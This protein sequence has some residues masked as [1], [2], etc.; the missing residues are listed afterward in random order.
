[1]CP[2]CRLANRLLPGPAAAIDVMSGSMPW[3]E[4]RSPSTGT[5][6]SW[7]PEGTWFTTSR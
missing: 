6:A 5:S 2:V 1:M 3:E 4:E 7:G